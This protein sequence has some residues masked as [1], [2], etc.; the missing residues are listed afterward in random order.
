MKEGLELMFS[1][2][3]DFYDRLDE[4]EVKKVL[5]EITKS[6]KEVHAALERYQKRKEAKKALGDASP[7]SMSSGLNSPPMS[8]QGSIN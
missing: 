2:L 7:Q 5:I 4:N 3:K 1:Y 6:G 8:D